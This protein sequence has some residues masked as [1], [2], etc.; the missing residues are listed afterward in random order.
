MN[1]KTIFELKNKNITFRL[2]NTMEME[3]LEEFLKY[4]ALKMEDS[5]Q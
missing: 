3:L 2:L 5:M 4:K 1:N